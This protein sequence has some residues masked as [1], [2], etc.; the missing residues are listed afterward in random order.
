MSVRPEAPPWLVAPSP[1]LRVWAL[2]PYFGGSHRR[3][4]E[5]LASHSR[6]HYSLHTLPGRNWKWRM[7]GAA[8]ALAR[9]SQGGR[10]IP[11][12]GDADGARTIPAP[13]GAGS[14]ALPQVLFASD[15]LD[16]ADYKA[17]VHPA[18]AATPTILYM[19][20]NQLTYPLPPGVER[21]LGYGLKNIISALVADRVLFNSAFHRGEF[22]GAVEAL[23][24]DLP[25]AVP[26]WAAD[27]VAAKSD[28]LPLGCDL[29]WLDGHRPSGGPG[30]S[31][32]GRWGDEERGPLIVW[33][34]RWEYDKAPG[35]LF[36]ALS[37]LRE[38]GVGFRLAMA[39]A[40]H[41]L[42]S[43]QF[44]EARGRLDSEIVQWGHV[45]DAADYASLLWE[46]D[47]VVSTA[48]HEFFG[49][50]VVEAL[51]CGCRPVLPHRLSYPEIVPKEAHGEALYGPGEL[52][53]ALAEA[54]ERSTAARKSAGKS[55]RIEWQRT[56]VSRYD[57]SA[58][59]SRYDAAVQLCWEGGLA[60]GTKEG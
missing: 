13:G 14:A 16:L 11:A 50:A 7:H 17:L 44:V 19:H 28:V 38:R 35:D 42:P 32:S 4:L 2:E 31:G 12:P 55:S 5:G 58:M 29:A 1:G 39:G 54:L 6:H 45:E 33:N 37:A 41:G 22:L 23:L 53:D 18:V 30:H 20:E 15:M 8:L 24:D 27:E 47:I 9:D 36:R 49:V 34:Q 21:D 56:W 60:R 43:A 26:H 10:T 46:A 57:W 25:D 51:Y 59:A 48:L 52:V 40:N 3:F